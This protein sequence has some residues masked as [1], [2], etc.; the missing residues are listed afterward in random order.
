MFLIDLRPTHPNISGRDAQEILDKL[1]IT[2][3]KNCVPNE[4]RTPQ[5]ASGIRIG[6]AAMTTRGYKAYDFVKLA[7]V[8]DSA[9]TLA[10][11]DG[12]RQ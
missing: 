7:K 2:L 11:W 10:D 12:G 9:L 5:E 8:I 1:G 6:T 4:T 3:N